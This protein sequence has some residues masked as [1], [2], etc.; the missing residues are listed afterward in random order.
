MASF[1]EDH[2]IEVTEVIAQYLEK[3]YLE[4]VDKED[5]K[6]GWFLPQLSV[7]WPDKS[8]TKV[9]TVFD[10]SAKYSGKSLNDVIY[11]G[12]KLQQDLVKLGLRF[13]RHAVALV[14]GIAELYL[15][16]GIHPDDRKYQRIWRKL[17]PTSKPDMLQ[18]NQMVF[19]IS[20]SPFGAQFVPREHAKKHRDIDGVKCSVGTNVH[21]RHNGFSNWW[22]DR[23]QVVSWIVKNLAISW[24]VCEIVVVQLNR[25]P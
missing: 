4:R 8:T 23:D 5:T 11:Q 6:D 24:N 18:F 13:R 10:G 9:R 19:G 20:S 15:S 3:G 25:S 2:V 21:G 7:L 14:C 17:D 22:Q 16:I 1:K 12:P